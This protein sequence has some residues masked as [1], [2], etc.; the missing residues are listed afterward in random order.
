[1][2][3]EMKC[4]VV[5]L[6]NSRALERRGRFIITFVFY[7]L[8]SYCEIS[9]HRPLDVSE[10]Y[11]GIGLISHSHIR[12]PPTERIELASKMRKDSYITHL[13]D[14]NLTRVS[15]LMS[16]ALTPPRTQN[17]DISES[18]SDQEQRKYLDGNT[19]SSDIRYCNRFE[20]QWS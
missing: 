17:K 4:V 5:S 9:I 18:K 19:S 3:G 13:G 7:C 11:I 14:H 10:L 20:G 16:D 6:I 8:S 1:M 2:C 12:M 15:H